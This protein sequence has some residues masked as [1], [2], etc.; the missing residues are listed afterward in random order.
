MYV[1]VTHNLVYIVCEIE[2]AVQAISALT[3]A[4]KV[5]VNCCYEMDGGLLYV[6]AWFPNAQQP[7]QVM[8]NRK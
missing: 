3:W 5:Y 7:C 6:P 1:R 2:D 4:D 8:Q